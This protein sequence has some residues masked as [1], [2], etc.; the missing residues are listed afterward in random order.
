M[1]MH[2]VDDKRIGIELSCPVIYSHKT[3]YRL[4]GAF[5]VMLKLK[6]LELD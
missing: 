5:N 2:S 6:T 1:G 4:E 3:S